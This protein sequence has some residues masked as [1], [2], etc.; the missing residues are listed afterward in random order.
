MKSLSRAQIKKAYLKWNQ[1]VIDSKGK[2]FQDPANISKS[3]L[4]TFSQDCVDTLFSYVQ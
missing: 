3:D 2:G 4:E 1:A